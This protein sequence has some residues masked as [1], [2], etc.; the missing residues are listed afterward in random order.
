MAIKYDHCNWNWDQISRNLVSKK[1]FQLYYCT[2]YI[3]E[4][5]T[6]FVENDYMFDYLWSRGILLKKIPSSNGFLINYIT[7]A[8]AEGQE[9]CL[10]QER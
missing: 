10:S 8:F 1:L 6:G 4:N 3:S 7:H 2:N 9:S 5:K